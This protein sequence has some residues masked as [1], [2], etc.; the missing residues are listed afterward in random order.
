MSATAKQS[1]LCLGYRLDRYELL[2]P[3]AQGGMASVWVARQVGKHGFAKLVAIK[4][5]LP[6]HAEDPQFRAMFLDEAHLASGIEHPNVAQILDLG[7]EHDVLYLVMELVDGDSLSRL[8]RSVQKKNLKVP[9]GV[10]L[11]ILADTCG[12]LH[13]AH[14]LR[15]KNNALLGV[16]HR[17][18]SPQNVLVS[19]TGQ[20]KLIDFG[21]A[22]A[23]DRLSGDTS[24]GLL[25]GKIH[26]MAPEQAL[27]KPIDRRADV[28]AIGAMLYHLVAGSPPIEAEN[29][30]AVL[31]RLASG[32]PP[33]PLP[34]GTP[35]VV[36]ELV[37]RAL[38]FDPDKRMAN[39]REMQLALED[40]MVAARVLTTTTSVSQFIREHRGEHADK[41]R[42]SIDVAL[43]AANERNRVHE[44]L[45]IDRDSLSDLS[46]PVGRRGN[47]PPPSSGQQHIVVP[48]PSHPPTLSTGG[49][50]APS[51]IRPATSHFGLR[52]MMLLVAA[53]IGGLVAVLVLR[54]APAPAQ[55]ASPAPCVTPPSVS[56]AIIAQPSVVPSAVPSPLPAAQPPR[57]GPPKVPVTN[58]L[59]AKPKPPKPKLED[60]DGF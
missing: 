8:L 19:S 58:I 21:V 24:A 30:L 26:Y 16:V 47:T 44:S 28:W 18:V 7:E 51:M 34:E 12:G 50:V 1:P 2:C 57:D 52:A 54:R 32:D 14:E 53:A 29:Q 43:A 38:A 56:A 46:A 36:V 9:L 49:V 37:A 40:A 20:A 39:A 25:K 42:A 6:Q 45:Q 31:H 17:D 55:P 59:K 15:D 11:R 60:N 41:R 22:K 13:A 5:I 3:I 4:T 35:A 10:A 23:R 48:P 27:G 33:A